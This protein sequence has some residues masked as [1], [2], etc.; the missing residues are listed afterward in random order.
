MKFQSNL[1]RQYVE[2]ERNQT[3]CVRGYKKKREKK[4]LKLTTTRMESAA[5]DAQEQE[6]AGALHFHGNTGSF[7]NMETVTG[8]FDLQQFFRAIMADE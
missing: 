7:L 2:Q 1:G 6:Q 5:I 4:N 8:R 3:T